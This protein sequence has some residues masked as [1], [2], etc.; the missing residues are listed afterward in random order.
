MTEE[1]TIPVAAVGGIGSLLSIIGGW[2]LK[3][4]D[5]RIEGIEK[6]SVQIMREGIALALSLSE[7]KT[8]SEKR[9]AKEETMQAS[10][11]R[12]HDR[13]DLTATAADVYELRHD[14]KTLL[15]RSV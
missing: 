6:N 9:F 4:H 13:L 5:K 11:S 15:A 7:Y 8:D 10:L 12:I 1:I 3:A 14:I 2:F